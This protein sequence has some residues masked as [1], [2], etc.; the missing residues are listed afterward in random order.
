MKKGTILTTMLLLIVITA[1][2]K[3]G[4]KKCAFNAKS[5]NKHVH[6]VKRAKRVHYANY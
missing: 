5:R 6:F 3:T 1:T 2:A 4:I